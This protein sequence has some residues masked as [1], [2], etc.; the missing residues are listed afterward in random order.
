MSGFP[1]PLPPPLGRIGRYTIY[2]EL[3]AGGMSRVFL[4]LRD[5][6]TELCVL[7]QLHGELEAHDTAAIRFQREA[8]L[9]SQLDHPNIAR[10]ID[11]GLQDGRFYIAMDLIQGVTL[12]QI[13]DTMDARQQI[14]PP[15]ITLS[16]GVEVLEGLAYAHT[17][18]SGGRHLAVVHRD[19]SPKNVMLAYDGGVKIIDFGV[20]Q[21]R[22]DNFQTA[23]GMMVGTLHYM[24]PEQAMTDPVDHRSDLYTLSVVLWELLSGRTAVR[25]GKAI[26]ILEQV[27]EETPQ[28]L[29][30]IDP[31]LPRPISDVIARGLAKAPEDRWQ[32]AA[33]YAEALKAAT[34]SF[35][36]STRLQRGA[37]VLELF[38]PEEQ[39]FARW[40]QLADTIDP[41]MEIPTLADDQL[42]AEDVIGAFET[43]IP[44]PSAS[45]SNT[46]PDVPRPAEDAGDGA[47]RPDTPSP[48]PSMLEKLT[49]LTVKNQRLERRIVLQR[50]MIVLLLVVTA[51]LGTGWLAAVFGWLS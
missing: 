11:A 49:S 1:A 15:A 28:P 12:R 18:R 19:L 38:P 9:V 30:E 21:G 31:G 7:K 33:E 32:T 25:D 48:D 24:S 39:P 35:G 41:N 23:P 43:T 3:A 40:S 17:L 42:R 29:F 13:L 51:T 46:L 20:A 36:G 45:T 16:V 2:E 6:A 8:H 37:F 27:I 4:A 34:R 14:V 5:G 44:P 47:T 50:R 26:Q 10:V 22:I